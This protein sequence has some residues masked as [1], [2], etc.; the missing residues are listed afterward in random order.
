MML[1]ILIS[2][3]VAPISY[4]CWASV[5]LPLAASK[6]MAVENAANRRVTKDISF[7]PNEINECACL[8]SEDLFSGLLPDIEHPSSGPVDVRERLLVRAFISVRAI[9]QHN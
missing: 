5:P 2:L 9:G 7:L 8:L 6:M 4:F 3:S 1:P